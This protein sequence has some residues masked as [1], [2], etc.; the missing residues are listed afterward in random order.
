MSPVQFGA[1][2]KDELARSDRIT[3]CLNANLV[4]IEL[5]PRTSSQ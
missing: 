4:D 1:K 5:D 2:Y 3:L